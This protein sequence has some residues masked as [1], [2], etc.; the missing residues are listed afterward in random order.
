VTVW[1]VR[2]SRS[3]AERAETAGN[4]A[5][6]VMRSHQTISDFAAAIAIMEEIKRLHRMGQIE[7]LLDRYG[8]LR[9][10]LIGVRKLSPALSETMD[11]SIQSA[12]TTLAIMEDVIERARA[13]RY[14]PDFVRLNRLLSIDIDDLHAVLIDI[15]KE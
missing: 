6:R 10:A 11:I 13:E 1:N 4:E 3:A 14:S 15:M 12:I 9:K 8:V 2:R 7:P 5:R